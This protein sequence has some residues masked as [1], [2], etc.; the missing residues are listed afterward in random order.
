MIDSNAQ[1]APLDGRMGRKYCWRCIV[2]DL[3]IGSIDVYSTSVGSFEVR[4][5]LNN[6][7]ACVN[8]EVYL[9]ELV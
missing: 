8:P 2:I 7:A 3:E 9:V 4:I 1:D 6:H 5:V